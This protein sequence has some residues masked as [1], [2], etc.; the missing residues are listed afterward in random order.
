MSKTYPNLSSI[1]K[2]LLFQRD[3]KPVDLARAVDI[4]PPTIHRLITGKSTRPYQSSLEPIAKY[5]GI[6]TAQLLGTESLS[7]TKG[8]SENSLLAIPIAFH[9]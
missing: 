4:P 9:F 5:F 1:L 8:P 7:P 2:R 6:T 3:M